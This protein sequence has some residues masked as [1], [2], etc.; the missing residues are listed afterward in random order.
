MTQGRNRTA[1][2]AAVIVLGIAAWLSIPTSPGE[3]LDPRARTAEG[4]AASV[5]TLRELGA[6]VTIGSDVPRGDAVLIVPSARLEDSQLEAVAA[7]I[8]DG[9][10]AVLLDPSVP[11]LDLE[12]VDVLATDVFG[13]LTAEPNCPL[14]DG[15]ITEIS[16]TRYALF[17]PPVDAIAACF[18]PG[19]GVALVIR[20]MGQGELAVL[21][22]PGVLANVN[23][24]KPDH[25]R[26]LTALAL[27]DGNNDVVIL[28]DLPA[29][30]SRAAENT[31]LLDLVGDRFIVPFW[32]LI[33]AAVLFAISRS[34][35]TGP[36]ALESTAVR[37]PGSELVIAIGDLLERHGH[38]DQAA[39]RLRADLRR[40]LARSLGLP[41][42]TPPDVLV[43]VSGTQLPEVAE[44]VLRRAVVDS[45]I[46]GRDDLLAVAVATAAIRT[47]IDRTD[48]PVL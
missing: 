23:L 11:F 46:G 48:V 2:V 43:D 10:R 13:A 6:T 36:P 32:V 38:V 41:Q 1:V 8:D 9:G 44:A 20:P 45:S 25:A 37:I 3:F 22:A 31:S 4:F 18:D 7:F 17:N 35:R 28:W 39:A 5:D 19:G 30:A 34:R 27:P 15:Y 12:V 26:L 47:A 33:G 42:D 16:S 14:L 29:G 40:D 21:G 24:G